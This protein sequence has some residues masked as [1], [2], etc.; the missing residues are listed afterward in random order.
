LT[1]LVNLAESTVVKSANAFCVALRDGR[2]PL[3][4]DHPLGLYS[5]DC[6]HLRGYELRLG[7]RPARL[8]I[9]SDAA[10]TGA[11]YELTNEDLA[12]EDGRRLGLQSLRVRVER[13]MLTGTMTDWITLHSYA[14]DPVELEVELRFD[15]DFRPMLE[16]RGGVERVR[17][18]VRR[19]ADGHALR[20]A[21]TGLD[22]RERATTITCP[23]AVADDGGA[24]RARVALEPGDEVALDVH[25]DVSA[26][27]RGGAL[28]P[29]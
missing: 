24:L 6:R 25:V 26:P 13:R 4:G 29:L 12:L 16:V 9:A 3:D 1:E 28:G 21:A 10:G 17:R 11:V 15:A 20:F 5:D 23:G 18:E 22:G 27:E 19:E 14:R 2:L 7:G 8:L